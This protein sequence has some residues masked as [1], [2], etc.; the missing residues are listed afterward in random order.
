MQLIRV[1]IIGLLIFRLT[2]EGRW[3]VK[4]ETEVQFENKETDVLIG[5]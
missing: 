2:R 5:V 1:K 4:A 3:K